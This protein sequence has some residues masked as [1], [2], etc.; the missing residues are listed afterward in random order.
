MK[1][2]RHLLALINSILDLSKV[3]AGTARLAEDEVP[4]DRSHQGQPD[5]DSQAGRRTAEASR[6]GRN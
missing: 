4:L 6:W 1:S 3:E 5:D 2:G